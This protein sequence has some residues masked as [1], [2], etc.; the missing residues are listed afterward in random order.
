MT[1]METDAVVELEYSPGSDRIIRHIIRTSAK[2]MQTH[3][4]TLIVTQ[5]DRVE[6]TD[7]DDK[8]ILGPDEKPVFVYRPKKSRTAPLV[9]H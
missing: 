7:K 5:V 2:T 3:P 1:K 9:V 4:G 6:A 8:P